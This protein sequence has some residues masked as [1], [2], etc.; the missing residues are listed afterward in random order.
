MR[1]FTVGGMDAPARAAWGMSA[2]ANGET[3]EIDINP[4]GGVNI[5]LSSNVKHIRAATWWHEPTLEAGNSDLA[6]ID[7]SCAPTVLL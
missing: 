2:V 3:V 7:V 4:S 5:A 1:L 6:Q